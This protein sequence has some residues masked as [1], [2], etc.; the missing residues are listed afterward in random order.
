VLLVGSDLQSTMADPDGDRC[1]IGDTQAPF[2]SFLDPEDDT[3]ATLG[4]IAAWYASC[5]V[6]A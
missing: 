4:H 2:S 3:H 5:I 1:S 6:F